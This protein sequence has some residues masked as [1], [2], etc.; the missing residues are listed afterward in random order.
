MIQLV[1]VQDMIEA[2]RRSDLPLNLDVL[3]SAAAVNTGQQS[4]LL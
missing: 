4:D 1:T 2:G 3:V